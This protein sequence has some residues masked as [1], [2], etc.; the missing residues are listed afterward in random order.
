MSTPA[1][2]LAVLDHVHALVTGHRFRCAGEALLQ[3]ALAQV[4]AGASIAFQ[5]EVSLGEAGR[6]DFLLTQAHVGLEVKVDGGLS[7]VT[8]Q[9]LRYAEREDVHALLLVTTRS[10]HGGLPPRMRGKPVRVAVLRGG[11]L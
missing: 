5:R 6:I 7:E 10:R 3:V 11:L 2:T 1:D 4:L 8:R 9:L